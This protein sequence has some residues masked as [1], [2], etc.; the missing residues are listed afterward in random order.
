M[1]RGRAVGCGGVGAIEYGSESLV[2]GTG[3]GI[4]MALQEF[5]VA[6]CAAALSGE[7]TAVWRSMRSAPAESP[8]FSRSHAR[9]ARSCAG[10]LT[11]SSSPKPACRQSL[12]ILIARTLLKDEP[13]PTPTVSLRPVFGVLTS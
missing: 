6:R 11:A 1:L 7:P 8:D 10:E 3:F 12:D 5:S 4:A 13:P 9:V 2:G